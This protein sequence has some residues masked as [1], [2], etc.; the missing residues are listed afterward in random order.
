MENFDALSCLDS[1]CHRLADRFPVLNGQHGSLATHR[2]T[3]GINW[4]DNRLFL[5]CSA[6]LDRQRHVGT[7]VRWGLRNAEPGLYRATSDIDTRCKVIEF[8]GERNVRERI[9]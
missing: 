9:R 7:E 2:T 1:H 4:Q 6:D 8:S 5:L 3:H